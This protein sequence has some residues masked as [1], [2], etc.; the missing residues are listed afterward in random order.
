MSAVGQKR[1][2]HPGPKYGFVRYCPKADKILQLREMTL[3]AS[4]ER[5]SRDKVDI[6]AA[7]I[8]RAANEIRYFAQ[9]FS[10]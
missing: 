5:K 4:G 1:T 3:S 8:G 6:R 9:R 2:N 7:D 10:K